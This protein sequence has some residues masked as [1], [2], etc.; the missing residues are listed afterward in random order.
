[1]TTHLDRKELKRPD[2]F[3]VKTTTAFEFIQSNAMAFLVGLALLFL[4]VVG[5]AFYDNMSTHKAEAADTALFDARKELVA[6]LQKTESKPTEWEQTARP[7]LEKLEKITKEFSGTRAAFE[8]DLV[9]GDAYYDHGNSSKA[10]EYYKL[11]VDAAKPRSSKPVALHALAYAY[12]NAK[13]YDQAI[14]ALRQ[15]LASGDRPLKSDSLLAMARDFELKGDKPKALEQY[16]EVLKEFPNT[17]AA[18]LSTIQIARI[19]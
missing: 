2:A 12:E 18:A 8:A 3:V 10:I 17:Q 7:G 14:E 19:K 5:W 11:A 1:M 9:I 6:A 13:Q 15:I 4:A 16:N